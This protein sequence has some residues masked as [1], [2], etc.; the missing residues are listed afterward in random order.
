MKKMSSQALAARLRGCT[1]LQGAAD[2]SVEAIATIV[3]G[4][5]VGK[6]CEQPGSRPKTK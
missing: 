6:L 4:A 2:R 5:S 1:A 3:L